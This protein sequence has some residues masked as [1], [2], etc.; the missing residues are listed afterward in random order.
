MDDF[1][2]SYNQAKTYDR[3]IPW[4]Q[5]LA[6]EIPFIVS[7]FQGRT[8]LDVA[9]STG[10]HSFA[11]ENHGFKCYGVD[12]SAGMIAVAKEQASELGSNCQLL[13]GDAASESLPDLLKE[14]AF[15]PS[16]ENALLMGNAIANF[17]SR[18][19]CEQLLKNIH[20]LLVENGIFVTQTINRPETPHYIALRKTNDVIVQRIMVPV[21]GQEHNIELNVNFINISSV[22]YERQSVS[23]LYL[24]TYE[25]LAD[26]FTKVGFQIMA[27]HGGFNG[28]EASKAGGETVVWVLKK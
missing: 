22:E 2:E 11:L 1:D 14:N 9:C 7:Q 19:K 15:P 27:S 23:P 28:E 5:R 26:L 24:F 12:V 4:E 25:E 6:R 3:M 18:A 21:I 20:N 16:Y 17:A 8:V 13:L 10:R